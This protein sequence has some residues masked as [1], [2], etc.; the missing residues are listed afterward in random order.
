M[1]EDLGADF[2]ESKQEWFS[3]GNPP[4]LEMTLLVPSEDW[5]KFLQLLRDGILDLIFN[6]KA[7]ENL[8]TT[9]GNSS[10]FLL[11]GV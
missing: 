5:A 11:R 4:V 7:D 9:N 3:S 1:L 8:S 10:H 6:P 2:W